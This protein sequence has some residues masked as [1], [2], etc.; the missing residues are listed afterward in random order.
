MCRTEAAI[1]ASRRQAS[2]ATLSM[3]TMRKWHQLL[4]SKTGWV[5]NRM[6]SVLK[7]KPTEEC[8][9]AQ[10]TKGVCIGTG[11]A[12]NVRTQIVGPGD[13]WRSGDKFHNGYGFKRSSIDMP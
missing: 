9:N 12:Q 4:L 1:A 5:A 3:D 6:V 10:C 11:E 8:Y 2:Q 13:P 7:K